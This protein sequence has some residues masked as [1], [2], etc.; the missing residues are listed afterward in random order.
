MA[1]ISNTNQKGEY[2]V[3]IKTELSV[4]PILLFHPLFWA[5]KRLLF[6]SLKKCQI[7]IRHLPHI[8]F[9]MPIKCNALC[10]DLAF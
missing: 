4:V 5:G 6:K 3:L 8:L 9:A 2:M 1:L 10:C 7:R